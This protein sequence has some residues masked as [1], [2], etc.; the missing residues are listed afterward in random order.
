MKIF[1][2][3]YISPKMLR[4]Y[5]VLEHGLQIIYMKNIIGMTYRSFTREFSFYEFW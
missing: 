5:A 2:L 1:T 4:Y 3:Y